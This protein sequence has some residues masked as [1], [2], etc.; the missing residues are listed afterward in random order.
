MGPKGKQTR[1]QRGR[2]SAEEALNEAWRY[3]HRQTAPRIMR[4]TRDAMHPCPQ[5]PCHD[6]C[7]VQPQEN[8]TFQNPDSRSSTRAH[9]HIIQCSIAKLL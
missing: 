4:K 6:M 7:P 9:T 2:D 8:R 5:R 1:M 3:T